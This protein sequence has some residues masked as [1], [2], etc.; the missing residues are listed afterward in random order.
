MTKKKIMRIQSSYSVLTRLFVT[1]LLLGLVLQANAFPGIGNVACPPFT[2][3][4]KAAEYRI[5]VTNRVL[6]QLSPHFF[7]FNLEWV[8][9]QEDLWDRR[10]KKVNPDVVSALQAFPGATYRYPGGTVS[11]YFDWRA[12]VGPQNARPARRAVGWKGPTTTQFGFDEYLDFLATVGGRAWLVVNLYGDFEGEKNIS[13]LAASA[14]EW[15]A[16]ARQ[17]NAKVLRWELGNELDRDR[18]NWSPEKY[19]KRAMEIARAIKAG[20]PMARVV[21]LL[22]DYDAQKSISAKRY[23]TLISRSL[24]SLKSDQALHLYYDG[25]PAGPPIPNR[26]KHLC[27]S[28]DAVKDGSGRAAAI[29]VTEHARWPGGKVTD[30]DWKRNW[31][32]TSTL[33]GAISVADM[34]IAL[35]QMPGVEGAFLHGIGSI[36]GPWTLFHRTAAGL[37]PSTVYWALRVLRESVLDQVLETRTTSRN[38]SDYAGGYDVRS[39]LLSNAAR[40]KFA[41]WAVNRSGDMVKARLVMPMLAGKTVVTRHAS[42]SDGNPNANN[43]LDGGRVIP[44]EISIRLKFDGRGETWV[45]L[46]AYSVSAF[47]MNN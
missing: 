42:L 18:F 28:A 30:P 8:G 25:P 6:K 1:T 21:S 38:A 10:T 3:V 32:K 27:A 45:Q 46:P 24:I 4:E 29:W 26:L 44:K 47:S 7:G 33:I 13:A 36:D 39:S 12:S 23:N 43:S 31:A 37:K 16:S 17:A 5:E 11:N 22:E 14:G 2:Q 9:F 20:D 15:A 34:T 40:T 19:S 35:N 41:L